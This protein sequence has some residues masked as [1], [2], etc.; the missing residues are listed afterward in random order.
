M[1]L[2]P[3]MRFFILITVQHKITFSSLKQKRT[4]IYHEMWKNCR[5]LS[6]SFDIQCTCFDIMQRK[7]IRQINYIKFSIK[8]L[9]K[10]FFQSHF[11]IPAETIRLK[12]EHRGELFNWG[13][14]FVVYNFVLLHASICVN[15]AHTHMCMRRWFNDVCVYVTLCTPHL[16]QQMHFYNLRGQKSSLKIEN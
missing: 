2:L 9:N 5:D 6:F 3:Q 8:K 12:C 13:L 14:Y 4:I 1:S 7:Y 15:F 11:Q 10:L 16:T